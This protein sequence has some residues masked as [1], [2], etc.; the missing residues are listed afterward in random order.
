VNGLRLYEETR[1]SVVAGRREGG[2]E[3][4][5]ALVKPGPPEAVELRRTNRDTLFAR[6]LVS[7][8]KG[9]KKEGRKEGKTRREEG[10]KGRTQKR[11]KMTSRN[12]P[13]ISAT[14]S[15]G[16]RAATA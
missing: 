11:L 1:K 14:Y 15:L 12:G 13:C 16:D 10:R 3:N 8:E 7:S 5:D 4:E 6:V 2:T 9:G